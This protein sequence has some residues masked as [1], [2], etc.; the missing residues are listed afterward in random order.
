MTAPPGIERVRPAHAASATATPGTDISEYSRPPGACSRTRIQS[1]H[2]AP[3]GSD[4]TTTRPTP[5]HHDLRLIPASANGARD[6]LIKTS[7]PGQP[8][9]RPSATNAANHRSVLPLTI[10]AGLLG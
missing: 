5:S 9:R 2:S 1:A 6:G 8:N 7:G 3:N 4:R 10:M